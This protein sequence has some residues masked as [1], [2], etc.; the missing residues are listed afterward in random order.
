M[1]DK[2]TKIRISKDINQRIKQQIEGTEY[3]MRQFADEAAEEKLER[4]TS[5]ETLEER[6]E[7]LE[8]LIDQAT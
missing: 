2:Y 3:S 4:E 1:P 7:R 8:D 6:V 5:S